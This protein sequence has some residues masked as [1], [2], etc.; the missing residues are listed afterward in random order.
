MKAT[1]ESIFA[2]MNE[3]ERIMRNIGDEPKRMNEDEI[4]IMATELAFLVYEVR[5][6]YELTSGYYCIAENQAQKKY[7]MIYDR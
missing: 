3:L 5:R 6:K 2:D 4:M 7:S 1:L